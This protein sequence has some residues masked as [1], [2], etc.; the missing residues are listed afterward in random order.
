MF[1]RK[2]KSSKNEKIRT[3]TDMLKIGKLS[4][5]QYIINMLGESL[6]DVLQKASPSFIKL[7]NIFNTMIEKS[8]NTIDM[9]P[10][11]RKDYWK[12]IRNAQIDTHIEI[13]HSIFLPISM[14]LQEL[15]YYII[16]IIYDLSPSKR[17]Y[18]Y[19]DVLNIA[20]SNFSENYDKVLIDAIGEVFEH[21]DECSKAKIPT[22]LSVE[23]P[24][25][26]K[27]DGTVLL[28]TFT[29]YAK[30]EKMT[31]DKEYSQD[32]AMQLIIENCLK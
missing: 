17:K 32:E 1:K 24:L 16:E 12:N 20:A 9:V 23:H 5:E 11:E 31:V 8:N 6:E 30:S 13:V 27:P 19:T 10:D 7:R 3:W 28:K 4:D 25:F 26:V 22:T 21:I 14:R 15:T 2:K 18:T 29:E